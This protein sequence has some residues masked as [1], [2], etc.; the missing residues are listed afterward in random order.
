MGRLSGPEEGRSWRGGLGVLQPC[1]VWGTLW[2]A[3]K[4]SGTPSFPALR[5]GPRR[6][7][8]GNKAGGGGDGS[9]LGSTHG[10]RHDDGTCSLQAGVHAFWQVVLRALFEVGL[11][12][13]LSQ[14]GNLFR[15]ARGLA[16]VDPAGGHL[17][18][19]SNPVFLFLLLSP[20]Q[21]GISPPR[22]PL[23]ACWAQGPRKYG[24]QLSSRAASPHSLSGIKPLPLPGTLEEVPKIRWQMPTR[25]WSV[26]ADSACH[27]KAGCHEAG[28]HPCGCRSWPTRKLADWVLSIPEPYGAPPALCPAG[29]P[30]CHVLPPQSPAGSSPGLFPK[31]WKPRYLCYRFFTLFHFF[32]FLFLSLPSPMTLPLGNYSNILPANVLLA[33]VLA[34]CVFCLHADRF[35]LCK[36]YMLAVVFWCSLF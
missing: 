1:C 33:Y 9:R 34:K 32:F 11:L 29:D 3:G 15:K 18:E 36:W 6:L 5:D 22:G 8:W 20:A 27:D 12:S 25:Q 19:N 4:V 2:G 30:A 24:V 16:H 23:G 10:H 31:S 14:E 28:C 35:N 26:K 21:H 17:S 7:E 13:V